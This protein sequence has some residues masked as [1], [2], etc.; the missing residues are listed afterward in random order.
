M[1]RP[2]L[3]KDIAEVQDLFPKLKLFEK[4][5]QK[6]LVGEIDIFDSHNQ[7]AG[8]YDIKVIIPLR[9]PYG[10][11]QLFETGNKFEHV[12]DRHVNDDD[13]CCICSLQEVDRISQRGISLVD[14]FVKHAVPYL[15]NQIYFDNEGIWANGDYDH[16]AEGIF[17]FYKE[18]LQ[19]SD[20]KEVLRL[21]IFFNEKKMHRNDDCYCGS[22]EKLKKCHLKTYNSISDLSKKRLEEDI[23][24]LNWLFKR[25]VK[26]GS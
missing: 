7:Y 18:L 13:S 26:L 2:N 9:Y 8:S 6:Q 15:A 24:A 25:S 4:K 14:F 19:S 12:P 21:V 17:Q 5:K 11:P 10:F 16:G 1:H 23:V 20:I 3:D 22:G